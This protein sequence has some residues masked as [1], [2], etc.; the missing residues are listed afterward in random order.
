MVVLDKH[1]CTPLSGTPHNKTLGPGWL[2]T[3]QKTELSGAK[4]WRWLRSSRGLLHDDEPIDS[5]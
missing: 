4:S 2:S 1:G 3:L 5:E